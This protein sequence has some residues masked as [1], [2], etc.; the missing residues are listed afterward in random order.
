MPTLRPRKR[1]SASS[2]SGPQVRAGHHDRAGVGPFQAG[3]D[4]Q[5]RRF[6]RARRPD[7]A[8][9]LAASY[10]QIDVF[11]DMDPG[12]A[13]AEREIDAGKRDGRSCRNVRMRCRSCGLCAGGCDP[14]PR[15]YGNRARKVQ[16]LA[17]VA[18]AW[19]AWRWLAAAGMA[20]PP[21][22]PIKIV[23][24]GDSLTAGYQLPASAAFP[25]QLEAALQG[26]G[27]RGRDR[28][29]RRLR[30]HQLGRARAARLV[31][32]GGHRC[33]DPG[34]RRQRHAAR[35][36]SQGH[37]RCARRRSSAA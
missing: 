7:Q 1:A 26:Q 33:G 19:P 5:Q 31:G 14:A 24:L 35:H 17:A 30:R 34:A 22:R 23:A 8:D 20:A 36:R 4:H 18:G 32:A 16:R 21:S 28:Q 9:R 15:S 10:M 12:G 25:A 3:H 6:A 11:E 37:A 13:A 2:S 27:A 29:C